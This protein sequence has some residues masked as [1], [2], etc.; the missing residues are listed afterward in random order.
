MIAFIEQNQTFVQCLIQ[1]ISLGKF[2]TFSST[3]RRLFSIQSL[4]EQDLAED[5]R[6]YVQYDAIVAFA[7]R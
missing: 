7:S 2:R 1:W 6:K 5:E 4:L 3:M